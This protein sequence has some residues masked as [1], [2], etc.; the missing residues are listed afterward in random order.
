MKNAKAIFKNA[1][2]PIYCFADSLELCEK[3]LAA[4]VTVIQ[5]RNKELDD[6]RY[7]DLARKMSQRIQREKNTVFI[8]ND[9]FEIA[10]E[11]FADGVHVGQ[12]DIS[13][14]D[15]ILRAPD[16]FIVGVSAKTPETA[17]AAELAGADYIGA[18]SAFPTQ[19]KSDA[20]VIGVEGIREIVETVNIPVVAIG[21]ISLDNIGLVA[22]TGVDYFAVISR[23]NTAPDIPERIEELKKKAYS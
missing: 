21:G 23:V 8:V 9:R 12:E 11:S 19:T 2:N 4:N 10:L 18:G 14:Q 1:A 13:C 16:G 15:V 20:E 6:D 3:L 17:K 7:L 5:L 22:K